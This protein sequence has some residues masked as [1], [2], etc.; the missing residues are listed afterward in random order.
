[1]RLVLLAACLSLSACVSSNPNW[2]PDWRALERGGE[3]LRDPAPTVVVREAP[4]ISH[5]H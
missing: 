2:R 5:R 1:M 3:Y 4:S